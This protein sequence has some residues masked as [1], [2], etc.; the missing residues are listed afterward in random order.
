MLASIRQFLTALV[1]LWWALMSCAGFTFLGIYAAATNRGNTW[2][3]GGSGVLAA[4][5]FGVAAYRAWLYEHNR[6][7]D[8]AAKNQRPDIQ[9]EAFKFSGCGISGEGHNEGVWSAN[10]EV[11][12][13][14]SLCNHRPVA[15]T[16]K[17]VELD[18]SRL[19]PPV[20]FEF[21]FH[22]PPPSNIELPHGIG[23]SVTVKLEATVIGMRIADVPAIKLNNLLLVVIDAFNERHVIRTRD[24]ES[25]RFGQR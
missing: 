4:L 15:T 11:E 6:Y 24:G 14:M 3:V 8:E 20:S 12:F 10:T 9:G 17:R 19:E 16:L 13:E 7:M 1:K 23:K 18:G 22:H 5:F 2:I 21:G 25:F